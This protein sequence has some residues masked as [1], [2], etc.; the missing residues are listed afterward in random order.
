[1]DPGG[2]D[3]LAGGSRR[4]P[5]RHS[6]HLAVNDTSSPSSEGTQRD[7]PAQVGE[8]PPQTHPDAFRSGMLMRMGFE[9]RPLS[10]NTSPNPDG[11]KGYKLCLACDRPCQVKADV[12]YGRLAA[13]ALAVDRVGSLSKTRCRG[14]RA[15]S[16]SFCACERAVAKLSRA[17]RF[18]RDLP[19]CPG[20]GQ[21]LSISS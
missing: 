13:F 4:H 14:P 7:E 21:F 19:P 10:S 8:G 16:S 5:Q 20:S 11:R 17:S 15:V 18:N 9:T 1:M 12:L 3:R 6:K 2:P